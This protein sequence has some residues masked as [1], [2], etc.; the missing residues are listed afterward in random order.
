MSDLTNL[1]QPMTLSNLPEAERAGRINPAFKSGAT[2]GLPEKEQAATWYSEVAGWDPKA[3]LKWG[4]AFAG[5]RLCIIM[6]GIAARYAMR[7]ASSAKAKEH[8]DAM[9]PFAEV[10]WQLVLA[11][12]GV[13]SK[14]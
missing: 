4:E 13:G 10:T 7:V 12:K 9:K 8:G 6:Q 5:Y 11:S 14:L 1:I 3:E 2:P